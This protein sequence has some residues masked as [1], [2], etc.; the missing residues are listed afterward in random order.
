MSE[1]WI[2]VRGK[3]WLYWDVTTANHLYEVVG[4]CVV[5]VLACVYKK[6]TFKKIIAFAA[7]FAR[8]GIKAD[9]L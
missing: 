4:L 3:L 8:F 5:Q 9:E 2:L 1:Y 6:K 7:R